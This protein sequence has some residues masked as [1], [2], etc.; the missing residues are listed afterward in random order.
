[1]ADKTEKKKL[2]FKYIHPDN[3]RDLYVTG[4]WGGLTARKGVH[5]H[6]YS[7]RPPIPKSITHELK[8]DQT[9]GKPIKQETGGDIVRL[10]QASIIMDF[11]TAIAVRDWLTRMIESTEK[12]KD[13]G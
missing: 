5:M 3:L 2:T 8:E 9:I 1:M 11:N 7:E 6:F 10:I 12:E 4:A 13:H